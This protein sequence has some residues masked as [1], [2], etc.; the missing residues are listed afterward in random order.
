VDFGPHHGEAKC[1]LQERDAALGS[2][3]HDGRPGAQRL[4]L[5]RRVAQH[6]NTDIGVPQLMNAGQTILA[7]AG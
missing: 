7:I 6:I 4:E 5:G 1:C 2:V 3:L